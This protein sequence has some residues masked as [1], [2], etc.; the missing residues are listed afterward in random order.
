MVREEVAGRLE[1]VDVAETGGATNGAS[2][3]RSQT[4]DRASKSIQ[5][6]LPARRTTRRQIE[7]VRIKRSAYMRTALKVHDELWL[8]RL[9]IEDSSR[10]S[11]HLDHQGVCVRVGLG[12]HETPAGFPASDRHM[13]FDADRKPMKGSY[14]LAVR[15]KI[16]VELAGTLDG[17]LH[18][19]VGQTACE[20]M[21]DGRPLAERGRDS[22]SGILALCYSMSQAVG[23]VTFSDSNLFGRQDAA[24][25]GDLSDIEWRLFNNLLVEIQ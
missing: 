3:I 16:V 24:R 8:I 10:V 15:R 14:R 12:E 17:F 22:D 9:T 2:Y 1:T 18:K 19:E 23:I 13:L 25:S 6:T 7:V 4:Q 20:L 21:G 11:E 5:G